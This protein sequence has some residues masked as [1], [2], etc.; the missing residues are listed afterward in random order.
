MPGYLPARPQTPDMSRDAP[1]G[2]IRYLEHTSNSDRYAVYSWSGYRFGEIEITK[3]E[4]TFDLDGL[5]A[6][7]VWIPMDENGRAMD[8]QV[9]E[10]VYGRDQND[11]QA[12][13]YGHHRHIAARGRSRA[14]MS[15][16]GAASDSVRIGVET[17]DHVSF[18]FVPHLDEW[19]TARPQDVVGQLREQRVES[20]VEGSN[21]GPDIE[22]YVPL[23]GRMYEHIA[24]RVIA[25]GNDTW[26]SVVLV[27]PQLAPNR[28]LS[29]GSEG[30]IIGPVLGRVDVTLISLSMHGPASSALPTPSP[31]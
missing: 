7:D 17:L 21:H 14:R 19:N 3:A 27:V 1:G 29:D 28:G 22:F 2:P 23:P 15:R 5:A 18:R 20:G 31:D 9:A 24:Q 26:A 12:P 13:R 8:R 16:A 11:P 10:T 25:G 30:A 6:H 4:A